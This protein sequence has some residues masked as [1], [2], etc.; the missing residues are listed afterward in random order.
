MARA[1]HLLQP[2]L[3]ASAAGRTRSAT[4]ALFWW[5]VFAILLQFFLPYVVMQAMGIDTVK[6]KLH[7]AVVLVLVIGAYALVRGIVPFHQR[8]R[9]A[10]GLM[11]FVF[12]IPVL[13]AYAIWFTGFS[14]SATFP[15]TFWSAGMLAVM[16]ETATAKQR[17]LLGVILLVLC[18]L[19][20]FIALQESLTQQNWFPLVL[21]PDAAQ[22]IT[23]N[24]TRD[25]FRANAFYSHPLVASLITTMAIFLLYAM[26]LPMLWSGL[27][28]SILLVGLFAFGGRTAL[29]V[30]LLVS[31]GTAFV[32]LI[33]GVI[34]RNL[35]LDFVVAMLCAAIAV[36]I[37]IAVIVTQTDIA[38]RILDTLYYDGSAQA[39]ATQ[40]E[41]FRYFTLRN[42]LFGISHD[43]LAILKYQIGL[44]GKETDIE[45][46]WLLILF[47]LG[48]IGFMVFVG[49]FGAFLVHLGRFARNRY[50]WLLIVSALII[51]SGSNSLGVKTDDLFLEVAFM[52]AISGYTGYERA[53]RLAMSRLRDRVTGVERPATALG[54]VV[55]RNRGLRLLRSR[56]L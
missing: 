8:S 4:A 15:E 47:D 51:D 52:V 53:P 17:R 18:V 36:P 24:I 37:L 1:L 3:P 39:R 42:W 41:I 32:L 45:N 56:A 20:V 16:L 11:L 27:L 30:T 28:F 12:G 40:W 35:K 7:P 5:G 9:E 44:G 34:R 38:D 33:S 50:G 14:G 23:A 2:R 31:G 10:P 54:A 48:G 13:A 46:F 29:A 6:V 25:E 22:N 43:D 26:R 19:N 49:I 55:P 21:D